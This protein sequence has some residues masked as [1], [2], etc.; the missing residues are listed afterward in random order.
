MSKASLLQF[1]FQPGEIVRG[2][3]RLGGKG[4]AL[5]AV[6]RASTSLERTVLGPAQVRINPMGALCN[7]HCPMCWLQV[8]PPGE[9]K[10]LGKED[11]ELGMTAAEYE[12]L[13]AG[14]AGG[15]TEV[16]VV[17]G[18]E[19]LLHPGVIDIF[20]S[21]K[22]RKL[23]GYLISNGTLLDADKAAALV[24]LGWDRTRI[25]THAGDAETYQKVQ[26]VKLFDRLRENLVTFDRLRREQGKLKVCQF[27]VHHVIQR[28]NI[29]TIPSMFTFALEVGADHVIF[30]IV[31]PINPGMR[32]TVAEL[33]RARELLG[34]GAAAAAISSNAVEIVAGL[35]REIIETGD[36]ERHAAEQAAVE[37]HAAEQAAVAALVTATDPASAPEAL[38]TSAA[39]SSSA[40]PELNPAVSVPDAPYRPANRCSVGFDSAFITALGDV[41]PCC[42][43]NEVM[44]N[45]REQSFKQIWYGEAYTLFRKRLI[46]GDFAEY[47][48]NVRCKL[49]SFLHD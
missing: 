27:H 14:M 24:D 15:L 21:I 11:R 5:H 3:R 7:H 45:V 48:S 34:Q 1:L 8:L 10:R 44:G 26:G 49:T 6:R 22:R 31:F 43:S 30:E 33:E 39:P 37:R 47:C 29:E 20:A 36:E 38:T 4:A 16:N 9:R 25:S 12:S 32:L 42:F 40:P 19:P 13:F 46:N 17:G 23:R 28:E 41:L 35:S 18:G 2:L